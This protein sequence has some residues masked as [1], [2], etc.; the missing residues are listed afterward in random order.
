MHF[1]KTVFIAV[2]AFS[3]LSVGAQ[4]NSDVLGNTEKAQAMAEKLRKEGFAPSA[5]IKG[6][7]EGWLYDNQ[8]KV[9]QQAESL[10]Q[11][12]PQLNAEGSDPRVQQYMD[13]ANQLSNTSMAGMRNGLEKQLNV[14]KSE[15]DNFYG[16]DVGTKDDEFAIFISF[17]M[18]EPE[19]KDALRT[20]AASGAKVYLKGLKQGH[21]S[22]MQTMKDIRRIATGIDTP[23]ET[24]FNP[25][26]FDTFN[27]TQV[28]TIIYETK[29]K[30][31]LAKGIMNLGWLKGKAIDGEDDG[32]L[33][34]KG[35]TYP[36][37]EQSI[38]DLMQ[39]RLAK[40]DWEGQKQKTIK[41]FWSRQQFELL[42][43]AKLDKVWFINPTVKVKADVVNPRGDVLARAGD[44]I[45]PLDIPTGQQTFLLFDATDN[46]QLEWATKEFAKT[47]NGPVV[48]MTSQISKDKGWD[49]LNSLRAHFKQETYLIPKE[50][51]KRFHL[52]ALPVLITPDTSKKVFRVE[53]F[54]ME[55][56]KQ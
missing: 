27:V 50:L 26:A 51:I 47:H 44:V 5:N 22:I 24:R 23:P 10:K 28:P 30:T 9:L 43:P 7:S 16:G 34:V 4:D 18:T 36:V 38:I 37:K 6:Q 39:Q 32:D 25:K 55:A 3:I 21:E 48:L 2:G 29:G 49:H 42:P 56:V 13:A 14:S 54:E 35:P 46:Q 12:M 40:Y 19:I 11:N 45:N 31:Y 20:A 8:K 15:A 33:G 52:T 53:Q 17:S 1:F 41:S